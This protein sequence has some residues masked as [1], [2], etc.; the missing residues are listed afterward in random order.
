MLVLRKSCLKARLQQGK[1]HGTQV[2]KYQKNAPK[3][4]G[5]PLIVK[6]LLTPN[7]KLMRLYT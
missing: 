5:T 3:G 6:N 1:M 4:L 2:V 7:V